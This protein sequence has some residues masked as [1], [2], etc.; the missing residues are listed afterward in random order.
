[1]TVLT[2]IVLNFLPTCVNILNLPNNSMK[3]ALILSAFIGEETESLRSNHPRS[4][5]SEGQSPDRT[6]SSCCSCYIARYNITS[7]FPGARPI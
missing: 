7:H 6:L 2:G 5:S 1:M 4:R 3:E